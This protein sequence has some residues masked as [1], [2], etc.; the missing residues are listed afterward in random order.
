MLLSKCTI[1]W[2]HSCTFYH[3]AISIRWSAFSVVHRFMHA[4]RDWL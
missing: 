1:S 4:S 2:I 3:S